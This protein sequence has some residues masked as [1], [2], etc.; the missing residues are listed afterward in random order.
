L[1]QRIKEFVIID[2]DTS[3]NGLPEVLKSRLVSTKPLIGLRFEHVQKA[4]NI[5]NTPLVLAKD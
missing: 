2:D 3:L 5:L 4:L 1:N